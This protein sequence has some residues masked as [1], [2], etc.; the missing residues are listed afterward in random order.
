MSNPFNYPMPGSHHHGE[1]HG[2]EHEEEEED[3]EEKPEGEEAQAD[4][5]NAKDEAKDEEEKSSDEG[6][7]SGDEEKQS[8]DDGDQRMDTNSKP[9]AKEGKSLSEVPDD[10][11]ISSKKKDGGDAKF[12]ETQELESDS[13]SKVIH[14][15]D[16]K[17]GAKRRIESSYGNKLGQDTDGQ[18]ATDSVSP[19][20]LLLLTSSLPLPASLHGLKFLASLGFESSNGIG[21]RI[22]T[23][24][25]S[26]GCATPA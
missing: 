17:G 25:P 1:E 24:G 5:E 20:L 3:G 9:G 6:K 8:G 7:E 15:P 12:D 14:M 23:H 4:E 13:D 2:E 22:A 10:N 16:A 11:Q 26:L 18:D 21:K 19:A